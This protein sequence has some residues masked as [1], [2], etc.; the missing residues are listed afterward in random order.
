M[1]GD[2]FRSLR[3]HRNFRLFFIGQVVSIAGTF[4]QQVAQAWLVLDLSDDSAAAV[5]TATALQFVPTLVLGLWGGVIADRMDKRRLLI[6]LQAIMG[7]VAGLLAAVTLAGV[8]ELWMVYVAAFLTGVAMVADTPARQAF[9]SEMVPTEDLANAVTLN[10]STFNAARVL[11]PTVAGALLWAG[12]PGPSFVVNALSYLAV[13]AALVR[14][15]PGALDRP[16]RAGRAKGQVREG[17]TYT[18]G[19]R[20]L[21]SHV[22]LAAVI[23]CFGLSFQV[24]VPVLSKVTFDGGEG[25]FTLL[26]VMQGV[27]ALL[28]SLR[29]ARRGTTP[30]G[31]VAAAVAFGGVLC[32]SAVS[33]NVV[34]LVALMPVLGWCMIST[35]SQSNAIV[36]L[37]ARP[38]LRGRVLALRSLAIV[39]GGPI[40]GVFAGQVGEHLG[41]RWALGLA[42]VA[43]TLGGLLLARG[44]LDRADHDMPAAP[45]PDERPDVAAVLAGGV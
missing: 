13:V 34:V 21:R 37:S 44:I 14:M 43:T 2:T 24:I 7:V 20:N 23:G 1:S 17:V 41:P 45:L 3:R 5:G 4:A 39:G 25:T 18:W 42:G 33:P 36:Q 31:V 11:G 26:M 32:L 35:L 12:G 29:L 9:I 15:D 27:G 6:W 16:P 10:S 38:S 22:L 19:H 28:G 30:S 40:A 8:V